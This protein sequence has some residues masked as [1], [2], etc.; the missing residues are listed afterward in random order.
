M[1]LHLVI[2]FFIVL[3]VGC[4]ATPEVKTFVGP[5]GEQ[6]NTVRCI[7]D[8][9]ACFDKASEVCSL[10]PYKVI[11]SYRNAGGLYADF[12]PG[13]VTW[14]TMSIVCG[15]SDGY[16]PTFPLRGKEPSMPKVQHTS[17]NKIGNS[18]N[19]TTY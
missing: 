5:S 1:K 18:V 9:S 6:I 7:K 16:M 17:C 13:P 19:C 2:P 4:G 11:N 14:Y 3:L 15:V 8:T 10:K 12:I